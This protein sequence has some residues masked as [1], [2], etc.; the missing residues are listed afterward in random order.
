M[1]ISSCFVWILFSMKLD[2][3]ARLRSWLHKFAASCCQQISLRRTVN[4]VENRRRNSFQTNR[5]KIYE[6][7]CWVQNVRLWDERWKWWKLPVL[8]EYVHYMKKKCANI[9]C[10]TECE[11]AVYPCCND[12]ANVNCECRANV[13]FNFIKI[14]NAN[15][16]QWQIPPYCWQWHSLSIQLTWNV[17]KIPSNRDEMLAFNSL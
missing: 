2:A 12:G 14:K 5:W 15:H 1:R 7:N 3:E 17:S 9:L 4:S 6:V 8:S 13:E 16:F 10:F 11:S